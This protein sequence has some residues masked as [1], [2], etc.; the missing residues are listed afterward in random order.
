[1]NGWWSVSFLALWLIVLLLGFLLLGALRS[2]AVLRWRLD[3]FEATNPRRIG[4][5]GL[6][7]GARA[8]D[9]RLPGVS[10][11]EVALC[12]FAGRRVLLVFTQSGCSPCHK[13]LPEFDRLHR[14]GLA[15]LVVNNGEP[16]ATRRWAA[17]ARVP[18]PVL[19][20]GKFELSRRYEIYATPFAFLI[21]ERGVIASKG[22]INNRQHIE[23]VL[24]G[25]AGES[26]SHYPAAGTDAA[27]ALRS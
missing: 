6:K 18:V 21:D 24:S 12:E 4:R 9:F 25:A 7:P 2:L 16:E 10:G 20:Q 3:Q 5:D 11:M 27:V 1:M 19:I 17:R 15:V 26:A 22:L 13:V 8:P 23:F 14:D